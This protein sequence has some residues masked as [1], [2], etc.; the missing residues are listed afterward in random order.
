M[1]TVWPAR[2]FTK[3]LNVAG[4]SMVGGIIAGLEVSAERVVRRLLSS[5]VVDSSSDEL[6]ALQDNKGILIVQSLRYMAVSSSLSPY[7]IVGGGVN[8]SCSGADCTSVFGCCTNVPEAIISS[9]KQLANSA[10][11]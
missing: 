6:N 3:L 9:N 4:R 5:G 2:V 1:L 8:S 11:P 7:L 10:M